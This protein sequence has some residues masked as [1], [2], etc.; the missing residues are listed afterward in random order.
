MNMTQVK[1]GD[2]VT[3]Y[4][5]CEREVS[6]D[7]PVTEVTE[8][9]IVCGAWTFDRNNGAEIDE[10]LGWDANGTGSFIEP[11]GIPCRLG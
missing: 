4:L 2:I 8:K 1:V 9:I 7:L 6:M 3:R 11:K 10:E 5:G